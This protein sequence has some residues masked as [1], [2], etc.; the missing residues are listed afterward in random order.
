MPW[1]PLPR[2][3][4]GVCTFPF[5]PSSTA[6]LPLEIGDELY[7]IEQGGAD[8]SWYRGYLVAPPSLLAGLTSVKGQTL[9]ARV[10]SGI[11]PRVCVEVREV[12]GDEKLRGSSDD[13]SGQATAGASA[14]ANGHVE[15]QNGVLTPTGSSSP[16]AAPHDHPSKDSRPELRLSTGPPGISSTRSKRG[17]QE[18]VRL[19]SYG[20]RGSQILGLPISPM[21]I[22]VRDPNAPKPPA[23]VPMLKIGDETPTSAQEPLVDEIASCLREW[24][25][26]KLHELLLG[27]KYGTTEKMAVLVQRLDTARRQFLHKVLTA[28]ELRILRETTVWDLVHG[29]RM[30]SGEVIVRSPSQRGRILTADDSAVEITKLQSS[31]SLLDD[32]PSTPVDEHTI[33]HL[34][35]DVS[36]IVRDGSNGHSVTLAI[37]LC[38]KQPGGSLQPLS[39]V[40]A[41]DISKQDA[42]HQSALDGN[43]KTL[44]TDLSLADIGEGVG[45]GSTLYVVFKILASE[46]V[47]SASSS[48]TNGSA[49]RDAAPATA[50]DIQAGGTMRGG[51][52]S[53]MWGQKG[54]RD[55]GQVEGRPSTGG[56]GKE[57]N[58][59]PTTPN[60]RSQAP[61]KD[62]KFVKRTVA[63]GTI[64]VD[65][66]MQQNAELDQAVPL[67]T[68]SFAREEAPSV[69]DG[70][71]ELVKEL[72]PSNHGEFKKYPLAHPLRVSIKP[73]RNPDAESLIKR[74]P[75]L[76][77]R[78]SQTRKI[79]FSGAP[80]KPRSDIYLTLSEASLPRHTYL[81]HPKSGSVPLGP[82]GSLSNLQLTLEVR[83]SSGER[84]ESCIY[85][86]CNSA[87]HTAWRTTAVQRGES[88]N[89]T[90]RLAISPEDVP[91]SHIVMSIA[92]APGFPFA[93]CWMPLW[94]AEAFIRD[95]SHSL[96]LYAYDEY[97]SSMISGRGAYLALPWNSQKRSGPPTNPMAELHLKTFLCSTKYS[98]DPT[99]LGL[100]KWHN[101]GSSDLADRLKR[102]I[103]VPEI[104]IVKLLSEV[105]DALFGLLVDYVG[106]D[107]IEDLV[108]SAL[109]IV[110][111]IVHDR[112]F[113]LGPLVDSYAENHFNYPTAA[114]A[115]TRGFHRLLANPV[116]PEASRKLR[117]TF[118]V[119]AHVFKFIAQA[120]HQQS[121][122][123]TMAN[124]VS[125]FLQD[126]DNIFKSIN[127]MMANPAPILIGTKTLVVQHFHSWIPELSAVLSPESILELVVDFTD[128]C[129][130]AQGKLV[131]YKL[132]FIISLSQL[133]TF[134]LPAIRQQLM[135]H[136]VRWLAPH[137]GKTEYVTD[138]WKDQVRLCCSVVASQV[139]EL[140]QEA[141]EYIPKL[142]DS[143]RAIQAA[144]PMPRPEKKSLSLLFPTTYPF[145]SRPISSDA[146]FEEPLVEIAAVLAATTNLPINIHLDLPKPDLAEFLFSALQVYISILDGEAFPHNWLSVHIYHHK[147]TMRTLEKLSSNLIESFLPDPDD[148]DQFSTELWRAFFDALL[149]LV[150]SDALALETFPEQKRRAVWKIAGDVREHGA[151]L[152]R[153]TWEAIGWET[154]TEDRELYG[155]EKLGGYQ[156]QY[157][158]GLVA[159]IV[160]LCLSVHEG[161]RSVATEVLQT[162]IVSEWTLSQDLS[163]IQAEMIDSLDQIFK[164]R[165]ASD[166]MVQKL[167]IGDL[168]ELFESS[169]HDPDEP[170]FAAVRGLVAT[171]D[172]LLD[173][174]AAVHSTESIGEIFHIMD[175][176]KLMEFLKHVQREDIYIRYVHQLALLQSNTRNYTEAGLAVRLHAELYDWD[177]TTALESLTEP[178]FPSQTAFERKEQL[179][180]QM[181][182]HFEDG[183]SWDNALETYAELAAQYENNVFDF[184]KLARTQRSMATI[185]E[186]ISRGDRQNPRFFRV[187]Y[188]GLGFPVGLRDKQFIFQGLPSD[189]LGSFTD[190][191]Q[192]QHPSAQVHSSGTEDDLEGQYIQIYPVS[193]QKD[194]LH[195]IYQRVKVSQVVR[196][197]YL[198]SKPSAFCTASRRQPSDVGV[199]EPTV[200][201]TLYTTMDPFP[202]IL[203]RSEII[204]VD[205]VTLSPVQTAVERVTRKTSELLALEKRVQDG[206]DSAYT[207]LSEAL[208][209]SVDPNSDTSV[210]HHRDLLPRTTVSASDI[211]S[212]DDEP[213]DPLLD[214]LENALKIALFDFAM[215]V[216]RCLGLYTRPA[217][218]ATKADLAERFETTFAPELEA[219]CPGYRDDGVGAAGGA[220]WSPTTSWVVNNSVP[221]PQRGSTT[222]RSRSSAEREK[223]VESNM[224]AQNRLSATAQQ[225]QGQGGHEAK[226]N[227]AKNRLSLAFL[228]R[229]SL[230]ESSGG[231]GG[232]NNGGAQGQMQK[233]AAAARAPSRNE[234]RASAARPSIGGKRVD[235]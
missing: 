66:L 95:G 145:P 201:K 199:K 15:G 51:R 64:R 88:W 17:T 233:S 26:T 216:K 3:A 147:A 14:D 63:A 171:V 181:I 102:F 60:H 111:G 218:Q 19:S 82:H 77:H 197:H 10:F 120:R 89:L 115:L 152:L 92:D 187:V 148:A 175:T 100:L 116:D 56:S 219:L 132:V 144:Q 101:L 208:M 109:V 24:H 5:Q 198:L 126:L 183:M 33:H 83:R 21:S 141:C 65:Q 186:S 176:L 159:P 217:H 165:S 168:I 27:R 16:A 136:T 185:Y 38:S 55:G 112:R 179:Y 160:E 6:D 172:E 57:R 131:L 207:A 124:G 170:L 22:T 130:D 20:S 235:G 123:T 78:I 169:A 177:T 142:V 150:G 195:P 110:L 119:G 223:A 108:F 113:N 12:L 153:R 149:K 135:G 46:I 29:N 59:P 107:E 105:F 125:P 221:G 225:E 52:R 139:N 166:S 97:T 61:S 227:G 81:S 226:A 73:F 75:T 44:F 232:G 35:V 37:H 62:L 161:L 23:P 28:H 205:T 190:R 210:S 54:K 34:F 94:T 45:A 121:E 30:L 40:F 104:E 173:L 214:P 36:N 128:S 213:E 157:V 13:Y 91:G 41:M 47:N 193:P 191:I 129:A 163:L 86:S 43:L 1:R 96:S 39:E 167:F 32:R 127:A 103:F 8:G 11:F 114:A 93:L 58:E 67:W 215:I 79:G 72:L 229:T 211:G 204:S 151:D 164:T 140:G 68:A 7:I 158:P 74:T 42:N 48:L 188:R 9:E 202:T 212:D 98:Q 206:E 4:F 137:W 178:E 53:L 49:P 90:I 70:W 133:D 85:P 228:R 156:V 106:N 162:M 2:I 174:L 138:L 76:L 220:G 80:T 231:G 71:D 230:F 18:G 203:R 182:K 224:A 69:D 189:R 184:A 50:G 122:T 222:A 146:Q 99:L 196:D 117:A 134:M 155:L 192:Q 118:K 31:M 143:Y 84:I 87:G 180:F 234:S 25:S 154:S 209:L 200:E 194:L